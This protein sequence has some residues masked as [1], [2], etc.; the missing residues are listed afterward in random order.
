MLDRGATAG[1]RMGALKGML[2]GRYQV[3]VYWGDC[4]PAK[5]V[6]Y[7]RYFAWV[8]EASHELL[9][10]AGLDHLV[11]R[12]RYGLRGT[13]LGHAGADFKAP[14]FFGDRLDI[15]SIISKVARSTFEVEHQVMRGDTLLL[16]ARELRIWAV[17]DPQRPAG[18]RAETIP[19]EVRDVL[20]G[21]RPKL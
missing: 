11:L 21:R 20:E 6:F 18:I 4:D 13:V 19:D 10:G 9:E 2:T 7:P 15:V 5:I 3:R 14:G 1:Q 16:T 8:D 12:E 17:E